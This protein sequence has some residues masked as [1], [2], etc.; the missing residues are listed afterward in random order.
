MEIVLKYMKEKNFL[1]QILYLVKLSFKIKAKE[2][3]FKT[4]K[5]L[6]SSSS[7]LH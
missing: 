5:Y 7:K 3:N 4:I 6:D 1:L 2:R